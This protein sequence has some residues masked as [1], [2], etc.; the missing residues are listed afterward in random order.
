MLLQE[1]MVPIH[2]KN[3]EKGVREEPNK[4]TI[5]YTPKDGSNFIETESNQK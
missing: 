1:K 4:K 2:K 3:P 5:S